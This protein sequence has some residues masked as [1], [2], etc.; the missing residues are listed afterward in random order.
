M[1]VDSAT[2]KWDFGEATL[3]SKG[4]VTLPSKLRQT[5]DLGAGDRLHFVREADGR[6]VV[7]PRKRRRIVDFARANPIHLGDPSVDLDALIDE[8]VGEAMAEKWKR[9][10]G[11]RKA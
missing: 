4:Q 11:S 10:R 2:A 5:F 1:S 3:T 9:G 6:L 7:E 8:A